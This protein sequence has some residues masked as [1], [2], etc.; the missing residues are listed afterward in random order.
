[1]KKLIYILILSALGFIGCDSHDHEQAEGESEIPEIAITQ[2]TE[3]MEIFMEYETA[4]IGQEIKFIVH[5]TS[6]NDFQPVRDGKVSLTFKQANGATIKIEKD[7]LLREGIFTPV[8]SFDKSGEYDFGLFY[9]GAKT[10]ESFNIGKFTVYNSVEDIPAVEEEINSEEIAFLKEQQWK[11]DFTTELAIPQKIKSSVKAVGEVKPQPKSY[12]EIVSPIEGLISIS[13]AK[14]LVNPGQNVKKG[15][16]LAVL[17]PP[18]ATQNS[19]AE[20]YLKYEQAKVE[21]ERAKRLLE[22]KAVSNREYEQAKRNYEMQKAGFSNYFDSGSS[23]I[24]FDSKNQSFTLVAPIAGIVSDVN[25]LPGQHVAQNQKLFSIVDPSTVWLRL[26]LYA[27]Q[28]ENLSEISGASIQIPGIE[29][30]INLEKDKLKLI[31]RG[32]VIDPKKRTAT[33]W[34]E[35]DNRNRKFMIGQTFNAQIYTSPQSEIL[36]VPSTAVFEDNA[37]KVVYVHS[38]GESFEKREITTGAEY[39]GLIA[40]EK[41]LKSG[42]RIVS[43][44]GYLVKLASTSEEIGHAHTH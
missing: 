40:I 27:S 36:T 6:M 13:K 25:I 18:L 8:N 43:R 23:S 10:T 38:S 17:V 41:G 20:I 16:T 26:E 30:T 24:Q 35:V 39:F 42:E 34:L 7:K 22:R 29:E 37:Q 5:L 11:I 9:H 28:L 33:L 14:Q 3:K 12:A 44:G 32:E 19:W 1:M 4:V 21:Y 15:Q 31:S 2:W